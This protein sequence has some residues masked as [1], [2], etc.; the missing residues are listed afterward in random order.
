MI[1]ADIMLKNDLA[2]NNPNKPETLDKVKEALNMSLV[3][4]S[5]EERSALEQILSNK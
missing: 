1:E 5:P 4:F 2:D 3:N